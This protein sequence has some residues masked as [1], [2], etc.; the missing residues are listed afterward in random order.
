MLGESLLTL[1]AL[2][3]RRVV[4][5]ATSDGWE[6][7][8]RGCAELLGRGNA[9]QA[10][11]ATRWLEE[12]HEQLSGEAGADMEMIRK[13]LGERWARRWA[14]LLEENPDTEAELRALVQQIQAASPAG[15]LSASDD[16]VSAEGAD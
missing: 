12:T 10:K 16:A 7:V 11:M 5:A 1:A 9:K 15:K 14:V 13:A 8:E 2:A 6:T 4:N 3:G